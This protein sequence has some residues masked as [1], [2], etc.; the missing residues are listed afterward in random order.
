MGSWKSYER[1]GLVGENPLLQRWGERSP[2]AQGG[3]GL[4]LERAAE[5]GGKEATRRPWVPSGTFQVAGMKG[6]P[7]DELLSSVLAL[8]LALV[9]YCLF[10]SFI[11]RCPPLDCKLQEG[12]NFCLVFAAMSPAP[13]TVTCTNSEY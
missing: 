2:G 8:P 4:S 13:R 3:A 12:G 7:A 6:A 10:I 11:V 9:T 5:F 1:E